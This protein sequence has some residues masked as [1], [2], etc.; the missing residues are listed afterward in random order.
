MSRL[1]SRY[2]CT[3]NA[4]CELLGLKYYYATGNNV[5]NIATGNN[6]I[7][8]VWYRGIFARSSKEFLFC[9]FTCKERSEEKMQKNS[10][11]LKISRARA[12]EISFPDKLKIRVRNV[13]IVGQTLV[14]DSKLYDIARFKYRRTFGENP[15]KRSDLFPI[16]GG[17]RYWALVR[18]RSTEAVSS[19]KRQRNQI[20]RAENVRRRRI[21]GVSGVQSRW[22]WMRLLRCLA[23]L[24]PLGPDKCI[25][26]AHE[27]RRHAHAWR[28]TCA[29]VRMNGRMENP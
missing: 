5:I 1:K 8:A 17:G 6:I 28:E 11:P 20:A 24:A 15:G 9:S 25:I 3:L 14:R 7:D 26:G 18:D 19:I 29:G 10:F 27:C 23:R 21:V 2:K 13:V 22:H 4:C 12:A 16:V